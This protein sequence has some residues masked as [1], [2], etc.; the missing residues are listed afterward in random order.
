[1]PSRTG[2]KGRGQQRPAAKGIA[3]ACFEIARD[4]PALFPH[5]DEK[6]IAQFTV[7]ALSPMLEGAASRHRL[8]C[9]TKEGAAAKLS[10]DWISL[11]V[12]FPP[13]KT[14]AMCAGVHPVSIGA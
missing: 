8:S 9:C 1:M 5:P 3:R 10:C 11:A 2:Y 6:K 7:R 13:S 14:Y 4:H 12:E